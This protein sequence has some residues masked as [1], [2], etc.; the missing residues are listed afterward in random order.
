MRTRIPRLA[1]LF[2]LVPLTAQAETGDPSYASITDTTVHWPSW[3]QF[4]RVLTLRD[5]NTRVVVVGTTLLGL[6]SGMIGTFM[7]LRKRALMGD[8]LSHATL[9]G[10]GIAFIVMT[11]WG[12]SGK[13]LPGLLLGAA[14]SGAVGVGCMLLIRSLTRIKEDAALAI[15]L[16]VFFGLGV[17][18]FGIIQKMNTGHAAGLQ[19]FIYG[20]T[21][22]MLAADAMLI[23]AVAIFVAA[24][25]ALLFKEFAAVCFDQEYIGTQGWPVMWID[26]AMLGLVVL[27]TVIGLQA[28]GL[29]LMI[30]MLVIPPAAARFWTHHLLT[31][32]LV[33]ALIGAV[34]GMVGAGL[35]ALIPRLP[36][37]AI[38]VLTA[39][40]LF[41]ISFIFGSARGVLIRGMDHFRVNRNVARQH[42]L[43]ALFEWCEPVPETGGERNFAGGSSGVMPFERLLAARSWSPV[44]LRR[45]LARTRKGGLVRPVGDRSYALTDE[46][47]SA[48]RRVVRNHRLWEL[49]LITHADIAPSHVDRDADQLE[50]VLGDAMVEKLEGLLAAKQLPPALPPSP[51]RL[52]FKSG[53]GSPKSEQR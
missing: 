42:L 30:A 5:H 2:I 52:A 49:Y 17:S 11:A 1:I 32:V 3:D 12:G 23:G 16:S 15:V 48:A 31:T 41:G 14:I 25:C 53:G 36:A 35:S 46:G 40:S 20:K 8:A 9:P 22:S 6:T 18:I 38:I 37:G 26:V 10:I 51:H 33:A 44:R 13:A 45:V 19:S 34:S 7:L 28:V 47:M 39:A 50:H 43:R 21:A 24:A 29:I 27:V 4:V